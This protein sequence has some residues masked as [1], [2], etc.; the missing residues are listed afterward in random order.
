MTCKPCKP[1][2]IPYVD[3]PL[4][5][6]TEATNYE[7]RFLSQ[8]RDSLYSV[9]LESLTNS[10]RNSS[11]LRRA[12]DGMNL[13]LLNY[14]LKDYEY[15]K[16]R[17]STG[18]PLSSGEMAEFIDWTNRTPEQTLHYVDTLLE[19][20]VGYTWD[21]VNE[22]YVR[23]EVSQ[24][25]PPSWANDP[26]QS[27]TIN[28]SDIT[29]SQRHSATS[30]V[31]DYDRYLSGSASKDLLGQFCSI[32]SNPYKALALFNDIRNFKFPSMKSVVDGIKDRVK[33]IIDTVI[34]TAKRKFDNLKDS[35]RSYGAIFQRRLQGISG[36]FTPE[37]VET[38][39]KSIM[40]KIN[41]IFNLFR[42]ITPDLLAFLMFRL[43]KLSSGLEFDL[44][45][46]LV[47]VEHLKKT[48]DLNRNAL[49]QVSTNRS[50]EYFENGSVR[51]TFPV[52]EEMRN[53]AISDLNS[54]SPMGIEHL[55]ERVIQKES[56][57]NP[58]AV[59]SR[60]GASGLMQVM[61]ATARQPGFGVR[62]LN[63]DDRFNADENRRFGTE[64]LQAM[65]KNFDGDQV[66]AL[67]AYNW[68]VGNA[69][70]WDGN[71]NSLPAETRDYV[72]TILGPG[73]GSSVDASVYVAQGI[74]PEEI[75]WVNGLTASGDSSIM[76][77][78]SVVSMGSRSTENWK[79]TGR[80]DYVAGDNYPEAGWKQIA[81]SNPSIYIMLRRVSRRMGM[82]LTLNSCYRSVYYNTWLVS[83]A[84]RNSMHSKACAV[85]VSTAGM[86]E[87]QKVNFIKYC[88]QEGFTRLSVYNSF[89]HVDIGTNGR[90]N[91]TKNYNGSSSIRQAVMN[92]L[93]DKF[94]KG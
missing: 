40:D 42:E 54:S 77:A 32:F 46:S 58:F 53:R 37:N 90:G 74:S 92:H 14:D 75:S 82:R 13:F 76:F 23:V 35:I 3:Y 10:V 43:C 64:Y 17:T 87:A 39:K 71:M 20:E 91:W 27:E 26:Y 65:L 57:G 9:D 30:L 79:S 1:G 72:N 94:R 85:D 5:G 28:N 83:G 29:V 49:T 52:R 55:V 63:W 81:I 89:I 12:R 59:N 69:Q 93:S 68:G 4:L 41:G 80:S 11:E 60:T 7:D 48:F 24:E 51:Y 73:A 47:Q 15:I 34:D 21:Y 78:P 2:T 50:R 38:V 16:A 88:S 61:P 19:T 44:T 8:N 70:R 31:R 36:I 67:V 6:D 84:A 86:S 18:I 56:S 66:R 22:T 25:H 45:S 62:P 33:K